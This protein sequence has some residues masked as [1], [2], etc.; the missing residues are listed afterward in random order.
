V[1]GF[2]LLENFGAPEPSEADFPGKGPPQF[3]R[4]RFTFAEQIP[5]TFDLVAE[6]VAEVGGGLA[7]EKVGFRDIEAA[8]IDL[9]DVDT[10]FAEVDRDVL[11]E[12]G[13]LESGADVV[14]QF[15]E[16][17]FPVTMEEEDETTDGVGTAATVIENGGEVLVAAFDDVLLKGAEE[18]EKEGVGQFELRL[19]AKQGS[20]NPFVLGL[21]GL[22]RE[23][24]LPGLAVGSEDGE[25]LGLG[26]GGT[27]GI[28]KAG[29]GVALVGK[30]VG[31]PGEGVDGVDVGADFLWNEPADGEVFVMLPGQLGAGLIRIGGRNRG[32]GRENFSCLHD[33]ILA[34]R[35][36]KREQ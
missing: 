16:F 21:V 26:G 34:K 15:G 31:H 19:G 32:L 8:E 22:V 33:G 2:D 11:P 7:G 4:K 30:I 3:R 1:Q 36:K 27:V 23:G 25:S 5:S 28:P 6:T 10:V 18:V 17:L 14:G 9:R 24:V 12:V 29:V 20:E 35:R 13:E